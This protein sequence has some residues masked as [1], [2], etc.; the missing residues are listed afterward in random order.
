MIILKNVRN[1]PQYYRD[2][3]AATTLVL[4]ALLMWSK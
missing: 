4:E 3:T 1:A 2:G